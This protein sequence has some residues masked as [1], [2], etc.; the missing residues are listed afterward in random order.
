M[1]RLTLPTV[2]NAKARKAAYKL[3]DGAGLTLLVVPTGMK[4]WRFRY[5][6]AGK[7]GMLGFGR[8][9]EV[10][11]AEARQ[12]RDEAR[13]KLRQGVNPSAARREARIAAVVK[14][15]N[16]FAGVAA[17]W[18]DANRN[19]WIPSHVE[20]VQR[21]LDRDILPALGDRPIAEIT[22]AEVLAVVKRVEKREALDQA[23][24]VLQ[25]LTGIFALGVSTLRCPANPARELRGALK[26]APKVTHRASLKLDQLPEYLTRFEALSA[27]PVTK[28]ALELVML[29]VVRVNECVG[30]RW[31]EI[32]LDGALWRIPAERMKMTREHLV[33]LSSQAVALLK[34]LQ[35]LTGQFP[36]VFPSPSNPRRP[37]SGNALLVSLRRMGY[38]AGELTIHGFRST[39]STWA[40]ESGF[41]F[42]VIEKTLAHVERSAVRAAYNRAEYVE[43]RRQLLQ[44]WADT[45]DAKRAGAQVIPIRRRKR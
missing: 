23:K 2:R 7:E 22:A 45:I 24:R 14:S 11:I 38:E 5:R 40:N 32:D 16:T 36:L 37:L 19:E 1:N 35:P 34:R 31:A 9:P 17:D 10:S 30:A 29:T 44:A 21:S 8:W 6:Y 25:R 3:A 27:E 43:K 41:D 12:L 28:A 26:K 42:D 13:T 15:R 4:L 33:P 20:R 18:I 39:F